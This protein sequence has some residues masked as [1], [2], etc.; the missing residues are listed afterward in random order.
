[1]DAACQGN[2]SVCHRLVSPGLGYVR[3]YALSQQF[4]SAFGYS[5]MLRRVD[6]K[7]VTVISEDHVFIFRVCNTRFAGRLGMLD[8][9]NENTA[10]PSKCREP[11]AQRLNVAFQ[12][13]Y[14]FN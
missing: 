13:K 9:Q 1:V 5:G 11:L 7:T 6:W 12:K 8:K 3:G 10:G 4:S 2:L 14:I